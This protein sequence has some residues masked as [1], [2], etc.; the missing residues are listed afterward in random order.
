MGS[1]CVTPFHLSYFVILVSVYNHQF[2]FTIG[3]NCR[4]CKLAV[5]FCFVCIRMPLVVDKLFFSKVNPAIEEKSPIFMHSSFVLFFRVVNRFFFH[6]DLYGV[7]Q[8]V[9]YCM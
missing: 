1:L 5:I 7:I 9:L 2:I 4:T 8:Y 3:N 6:M